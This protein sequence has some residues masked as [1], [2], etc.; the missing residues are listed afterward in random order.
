MEI[1]KV[2][3]SVEF[4]SDFDEVRLHAGQHARLHGTFVDGTR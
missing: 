2:R 3:G 4:Q 1:R